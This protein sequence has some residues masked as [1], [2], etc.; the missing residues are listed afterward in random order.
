MLFELTCPCYLTTFSGKKCLSGKVFCAFLYPA[1]RSSPV[2]F[3][4]FVNYH[5]SD[6]PEVNFLKTSAVIGALCALNEQEGSSFGGRAHLTQFHHLFNVP[7]A[8]GSI[9]T[10]LNPVQHLQ[11]RSGRDPVAVAV[12]PLMGC[13]E[14][15]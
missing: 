9:R 12:R 6:S 15:V 5:P 4:S 8:G 2:H 11:P 7:G 3:L 1:Y 13:G 10:T 14:G